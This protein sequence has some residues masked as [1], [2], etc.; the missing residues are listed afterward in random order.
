MCGCV[1]EAVHRA[2]QI[3]NKCLI[4]FLDAVA[5][6]GAEAEGLFPMQRGVGPDG[7]RR[8]MRL[9]AS[10]TAQQTGDVLW[11]HA[12]AGEDLDAALG[13]IVQPAQQRGAFPGGP[14]LTAG[15]HPAK[16]EIDELSQA[17]ERIGEQI[18]SAMED[19]R[20]AGGLLDEHLTA[21]GVDARPI[22]ED[23]DDKAFGVMFEEE[24]EVAPQGIE[25]LG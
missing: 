16:T 11:P 8:G 13:A 19:Q 15:E 12:A 1:C 7:S 18:E 17:R 3:A 20:S 2:P 4:R 22:I 6:G 14:F 9:R 21:C 10:G 24:I 23:A 25:V 5:A